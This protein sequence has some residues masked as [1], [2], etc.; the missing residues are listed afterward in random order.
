MLICFQEKR[1]DKKKKKKK[2]E[3]CGFQSHLLT[4]SPWS[5]I[6]TILPSY[7]FPYHFIFTFNTFTFETQWQWRQRM[8]VKSFPRKFWEWRY[9][10]FY[11]IILFTLCNIYIE[12]LVINIMNLILNFISLC[13]EKLNQSIEIDSV[14]N[15]EK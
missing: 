7:Y 3:T 15:K 4:I 13:K 11:F 1:E 9:F 8:R 2:R 6:L 5:S 12:L 10:L 14:K